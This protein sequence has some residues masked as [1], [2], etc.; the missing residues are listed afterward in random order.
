[1]PKVPFL[2]DSRH[3]PKILE[4][5]L[6]N[7]TVFLIWQNLSA[8]PAIQQREKFQHKRARPGNWGEWPC[9]LKCCNKNQKVPSSNLTR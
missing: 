6:H 4:Y 3:C 1:M 9:G 8:V 5:T 7:T 2:K